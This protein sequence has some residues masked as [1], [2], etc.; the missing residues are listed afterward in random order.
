MQLVYAWSGGLTSR[1]VLVKPIPASQCLVI[2]MT[3]ALPIRVATLTK[4]TIG[5]ATR[6]TLIKATMHQMAES[7]MSI[8]TS[9]V[10]QVYLRSWQVLSLKI[11]QGNIILPELL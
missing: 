4:V 6:V 11:N 5:R 2:P 3:G 7:L 8:I 9:L 1:D 10:F